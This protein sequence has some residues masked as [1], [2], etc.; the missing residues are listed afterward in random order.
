MAYL[1]II[2]TLAALSAGARADST[3]VRPPHGI[4]YEPTLLVQ[5]GVKDLDRAIRFYGDMLGF[6]V[7]ERR[8]DLKFAHLATNVA[9][10][11]IGLSEQPEPRGSGSVLL[12][13]GVTDV[14]SARSTLE[15]RGVTFARPTVI[16]PGKVAL[17]EFADLDGNRLRLAGPPPPEGSAVPQVER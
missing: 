14:A 13:I 15:A 11:Q 3:P 9:G 8:D 17:A 2:V 12:N 16:I 7:T 5:V 1:W 6:V 10:L 4:T